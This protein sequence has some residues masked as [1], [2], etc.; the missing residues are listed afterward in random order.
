MRRRRL[1]LHGTTPALLLLLGGCASSIMIHP[2]DSATLKTVKVAARVAEAIPTLGLV[3]V[4]YACARDVCSG[5]RGACDAQ[6]GVAAQVW[7]ACHDHVAVQFQAAANSLNQTTANFAPSRG[8]SCQTQCVRTG[9][10][11]N[12][13]ER[14]N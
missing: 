11:L 14:C 13:S 2:E 10:L 8:V 5:L 12:C 7:W 6:R 1:T 3:E 9:N 4:Y